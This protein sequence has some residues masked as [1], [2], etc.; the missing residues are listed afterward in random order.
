MRRSNWKQASIPGK[1]GEF[2][3]APRESQDVS[4]K[5]ANI[6]VVILIG[7]RQGGWVGRKAQD[8]ARQKILG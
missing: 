8:A 1:S 2:G 7:K 6:M 4:A 3:G 5:R